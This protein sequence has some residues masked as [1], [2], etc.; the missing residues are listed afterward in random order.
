MKISGVEAIPFVLPYVEPFEMAGASFSEAA[1]V[2]IRVTTDDGV[3][4]VAEAVSRPSIY[5]ESQSSIVAAVRDWFGPGL[6]GRDPLAAEQVQPVLDAVANN[7]T[8]KGAL[9]IALH[10]IMGKVA[11]MPSWRLLGGYTTQLK[12]TRMLSLGVVG[13]VVADA[14]GARGEHGIDSFKVKIGNDIKFNAD[15]LISLRRELGDDATIYVD[16]NQSLTLHSAVETVRRAESA[17]LEFLEEP[18]PAADLVGRARL[19]ATSAVPIMADES[20]S[21]LA[22]AG[23]QLTH[24]SARALS[25]KTARTGYTASQRILGLAR[26]F[27]CRAVVGSQGDSA[28]GAISSA[29][30]AGAYEWTGREPAELDYFLRLKDQLVSEPPEIADGR[31]RVNSTRAGVGLEIDESKLEHYRTDQ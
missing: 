18:L 15:L 10:D 6:V 7:N 28:I 11:N 2:L 8:A 12:V 5:G 30:F 13:Q 20:A 29:T 9:D 14:V 3:V 22:Q 23:L 25:V 1:H 21:S 27:G 4:G 19:A 24:G 16:A 17:A 26:G 31:L